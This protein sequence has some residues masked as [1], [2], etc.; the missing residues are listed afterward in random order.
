MANPKRKISRTRRDKRRTHWKLKAPATSNCS[1][2]HQPKLPHRVCPHC[3]Y[4]AGRMVYP[5]KE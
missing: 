4:Y 5:P 2:C 3:G 1:Q